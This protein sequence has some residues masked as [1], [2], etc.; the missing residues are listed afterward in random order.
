VSFVVCPLI[1]AIVALVLAAQASRTIRDSGGR[2]G[3]KGMVTAARIIAVLNIVVSLIVGGLL[4]W[5]AVTADPTPKTPTATTASSSGGSGSPT[6]TTTAEATGTTEDAQEL[7]GDAY[8]DVKA[9]GPGTCLNDTE[10]ADV[11]SCEQAH[12]AELFAVVELDGIAYPGDKKVQDDAERHCRTEFQSFTG[13][14]LD[15]QTEYEAF[16]V[17]PKR[18]AWVLGQRDVACVLTG[19]SGQKLTG[20]ARGALA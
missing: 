11:V 13:A 14:D 12:D 9:E 20:S 2:V 7:A 6:E 1:L 19:P 15:E 5:A 8:D 16:T 3:G 17:T 4:I 18:S 10:K